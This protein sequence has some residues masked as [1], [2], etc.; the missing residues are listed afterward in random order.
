MMNLRK[1]VYIFRVNWSYVL[2]GVS[3]CDGI[4][5]QLKLCA[6]IDM[7]RQII[8]KVKIWTNG[9]KWEGG[10]GKQHCWLHN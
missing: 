7:I 10:G 1:I 5:W 9:G 3:S 4:K 2:G 8:V 6:K